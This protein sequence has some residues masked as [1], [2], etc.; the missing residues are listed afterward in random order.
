MQADLNQALRG[1]PIGRFWK[2]TLAV[3]AVSLCC[4]S[5]FIVLCPGPLNPLN[6]SWLGG[7]QQ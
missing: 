7:A 1:R 4:S 6:T 5:A 2:I 3:A